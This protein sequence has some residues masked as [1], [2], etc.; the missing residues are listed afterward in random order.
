LHEGG[1]TIWSVGWQLVSS[2]AVGLRRI[3]R[4][5]E[6]GRLRRAQLHL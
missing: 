1:L 5:P 2:R 6:M 4:A 3:E